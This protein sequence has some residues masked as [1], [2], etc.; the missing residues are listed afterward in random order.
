MAYGKLL[1]NK[2]AER[3]LQRSTDQMA[4][5]AF[6]DGEAMLA[7]PFKWAQERLADFG[8]GAK[9]NYI[10]FADHWVKQF[11]AWKGAIEETR[12]R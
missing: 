8:D 5:A 10:S 12:P 9:D 2:M 7:Q 3:G 11:Q 1:V 6:D 4:S